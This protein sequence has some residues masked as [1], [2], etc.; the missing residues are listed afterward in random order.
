MGLDRS[1]LLG[2][3]LAVEDGAR[4]GKANPAL[5]ECAKKLDPASFVEFFAAE[6]QAVLTAPEIES[7][8]L[9]YS[10]S[11]GQK[12]VEAGLQQ[13][14]RSAGLSPPGAALTFT[15]AEARENDA[16]ARTSAGEKLIVKQ[17]LGTPRVTSA[18]QSHIGKLLS[19]C[20]QN[21]QRPR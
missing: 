6:I 19:T 3:R 21:P 12:S 14:Y 16:F 7:A 20:L 5:V 9:F 13:V 17:V 11:A 1:A 18:V 10:S 15:A 4:E 2:I 8:Q